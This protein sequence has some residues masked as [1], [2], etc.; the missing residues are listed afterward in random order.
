MFQKRSESKC[1]VEV[2]NLKFDWDCEFFVS[3]KIETYKSGIYTRMSSIQELEELLAAQSFREKNKSSI[4]ELDALLEQTVREKNNSVKQAE[5]YKI[6]QIKQ[7]AS[8]PN[9]ITREESDKIIK[10]LVYNDI[11]IPKNEGCD[12]YILFAHWYTA[13]HRESGAHIIYTKGKTGCRLW[14][15]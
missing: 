11:F 3:V 10:E 6:Q 2:F 14:F 1:M 9:P 12:K 4:Q 15:D 13:N 7:F 5:L 8:L